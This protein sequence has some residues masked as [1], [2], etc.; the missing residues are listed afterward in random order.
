MASMPA[1]TAG[2]LICTLGASVS[3]WR[4]CSAMRSAERLSVG[5]IWIERRPR[6]PWLACQTGS[7]IFQP[8]TAIS[9]MTCQV[10]CW[11]VHVG[12]SAAM[13]RT[14]GA[15][16]SYSCCMTVP[17]MTGLVVAPTAPFSMA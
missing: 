11:S 3:K 5:S 2:N 6:W 15:H 9:S 4:A 8:R 10:T 13:A 1:A 12:C 17:T 16:V 7:S 14:R